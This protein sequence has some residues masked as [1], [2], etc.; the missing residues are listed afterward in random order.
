MMGQQQQRVGVVL[1]GNEL[2]KWLEVI[3]TSLAIAGLVPVEVLSAAD[4]SVTI[5][6]LAGN[7]VEVIFS[8]ADHSVLV[9]TI[10]YDHGDGYIML[11]ASVPWLNDDALCSTFVPRERWQTLEEVAATN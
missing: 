5:R 4:L 8:P 10:T 11:V 7:F 9:Q 1:L 2:E 6:K 3:A